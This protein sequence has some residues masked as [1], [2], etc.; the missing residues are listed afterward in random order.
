MTAHSRP[1]KQFTHNAVFGRVMHT[2]REGRGKERER[3][4][5]KRGGRQGRKRT[6]ER[7]G[8]EEDGGDKV[9]KDNYFLLQIYQAD[10]PASTAS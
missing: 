10:S 9:L 1:W 3:G 6:R 2:Y 7:G 4:G 8:E 5:E